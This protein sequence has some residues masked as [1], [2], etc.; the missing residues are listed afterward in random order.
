MFIIHKM[1]N[2]PKILQYIC[3]VLTYAAI[4]YA[5][6]IN[7]SNTC[8]TGQHLGSLY[9]FSKGRPAQGIP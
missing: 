3:Y 9:Q 5:S 6:Q 2:F 8:N 1:F 7:V 4:G